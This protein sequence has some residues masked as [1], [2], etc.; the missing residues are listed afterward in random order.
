MESC[1]NQLKHW[2]L[3]TTYGKPCVP[4]PSLR[5][6][7]STMNAVLNE[8]LVRMELTCKIQQPS[9]G[10]PLSPRA[11]ELVG[12]LDTIEENPSCRNKAQTRWLLLSNDMALLEKPI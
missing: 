10:L 11:N 5:A 8:Y 6:P 1:G 2:I 9:I 4:W 12:G 7:W 3:D